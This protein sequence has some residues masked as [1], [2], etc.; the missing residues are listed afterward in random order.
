MSDEALR[1]LAEYVR[2]SLE[3]HSNSAE[4]RV[5][6]RCH[7]YRDEQLPHQPHCPVPSFEQAVRAFLADPP[8]CD[9]Q[10]ALENDG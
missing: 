8:A 9:A 10:E 7:T 3:W 5:C 1:L 2:D 6:V 4:P